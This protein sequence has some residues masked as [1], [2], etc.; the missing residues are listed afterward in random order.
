MYR[1]NPKA[2][3]NTAQGRAH[4]QAPLSIFDNRFH[5]HDV[6][7]TDLTG[8]TRHGFD[9][10]TGRSVLIKFVHP[11]EISPVLLLQ[12][13]HE[14]Q[15]LSEINHPNIAMLL[16][17]G[18]EQGWFWLVYEF[19]ASE[20]LQTRFTR[21]VLSLTHSLQIVEQILQATHALHQH[22][23]VPRSLRPENVYLREDGENI[24]IRLAAIDSIDSSLFLSSFDADSKHFL[25]L[26]ECIPPEQSGVIDDAFT[27]L[28]NIYAVGCLLF[29]SLSGRTPYQATTLNELLLRQAT[30]QVPKLRELGVIVPRAVDEIIQRAMSREQQERYQSTRAMADD[31]RQL[32]DALATGDSDPDVSIG[33]SDYRKSLLQPSFVARTKE[34]DQLNTVIQRTQDGQ[35]GLLFL[36]GQS[37]F[38]KS[39]LTLEFTTRATQHGISVYRGQATSD[40]VTSP[41]ELLEGIA[42]GFEAACRANP[43]L[44]VT[45]SD[46][47]QEQRF[48]VA[49]ALPRLAKLLDAE[50]TDREDS[51]PAGESRTLA[52]LVAFL[53]ALGS[54]DCPAVV[55]LDDCQWAADLVYGLLQRWKMKHSSQQPLQ[56]FVQLVVIFREEE[57]A[58]TDA[59]RKITP[60]A[61]IQLGPLGENDVQRLVESMAGPL[62]KQALETI[63]RLADGVPFMASAILHGLVESQALLPGANGWEVDVNEIVKARS[64]SHAAAFLSQRMSQLRPDTRRLLSIGAV[65][66]SHFDLMAAMELAG[67]S[68]SD[69]IEAVNDARQRH[70][71]WCQ[72]L[73]GTCSFVHDKVRET[74]LSLL[75]D[76]DRKQLHGN[77]ATFLSLKF[78][79]RAAELA[80]HFDAAGESEQ[81]LPYALEAASFAH[82]RHALEVAEQQYAIAYR[83]MNYAS[84]EKRFAITSNLGEVLMLRGKYGPAEKMLQE[85]SRWTLGTQAQA[86]VRGMQGELNK[87]RGDMEGAV[88]DFEAALQLLGRSFPKSKLGVSIAI[89]LG[90]L[91]QFLHTILPSVFV[92]QKKRLPNERERLIMRLHSELSHGYWYCRSVVRCLC[93]HM[94][95]MNFGE[96][97]LPSSELAQAYSDHAPAMLLMGW[98]QRGIWYVERSYQIR[99]RQ[100]D[101]W[102]QGQSLSFHGIIYYAAARYEECI[103]KCRRAVQILERTGDFWQVH[104]ARYQIAA[105]YY[106]LG[107]IE[108]ALEECRR[109][110]SSGMMLGDEQAS[111]II[112]DVWAR[113]AIDR[114]PES[115]L[116]AEVARVR[117][118]AQGQAQVTLARAVQFIK[119]GDH[120]QAG[121]L[122]RVTA[123]NVE[124]A[125][126]AN[127]Y[128]MPVYSWHATAWRM[129]AESQTALN[130][131]QRK[132]CLKRALRSL[133][134]ALGQSWR[135]KNELPHLYRELALVEAMS[136]RSR[137]ARRAIKASIAIAVRQQAR[138]EFAHTQAEMLRIAREFGWSNLD[139]LTGPVPA[140]FSEGQF[141][142]LDVTQHRSGVHSLSLVDRFETLMQSG[143]NISSALS[144]DVICSETES[145]AK[146]LLRCESVKIVW[147]NE[148]G[149]ITHFASEPSSESRVDDDLI[150]KAVQQRTVISRIPVDLDTGLELPI[151]EIVAPILVRNEVVA[152]LVGSHKGRKHIFGA[153]EEKIAKFIVNLAG[154]AFENAEGFAQLEQLNL[155]L[156]HRVAERT[157]ALQQRAEQ[158]TLSND[159]LERVA[160]ELRTTQSQLVVSK[161]IAEEANSAKSRFLAAMSHEIRTPMN[162]IIGMSELALRSDLDRQQQTYLQTVR[163]SAKSL[164]I[165]LNDILDFSKIEAGKMEVD[166]IP[167]N[168]HDSV[169]DAVRL[170]AA[171]A[172]QKSLDLNCRIRP[173]VSQRLI[174]DPNRLRQILVNL[175]G[176]AMKFTSSGSVGVEV[177]QESSDQFQ[178]S[179]HVVVKDTGIGIPKDVQARIFSPF[180][181]GEASVTRRYGG[182]GL[183]L[184]I[185]SQLVELMNGRIWVES[186]PGIGSEFHFVIS[187]SNDQQDS[188]DLLTTHSA[189]HSSSCLVYSERLDVLRT[190][191]EDLPSFGFDVLGANSFE[192]AQAITMLPDFGDQCT[193]LFD[194]DQQPAS[195]VRSIQQ[196]ISH[197]A[198]S[199][200]SFVIL[201]PAGIETSLV[202]LRA[203]GVTSILEKPVTYRVITDT[204]TSR[205]ISEEKSTPPEQLIES[206]HPP[207][208]ILVVD[209]SDINLEV[210][211]GILEWFG[212]DVEIASSGAEA[213][214][215]L[216]DRQFDLVFMDIEMP[217]MDGL[218]TMKHYNSF[219]H[220]AGRKQ[221]TVYAMTA[222]VLDSMKADCLA[223][224]MVGF[225]SKPIEVSELEDVLTQHQ[226]A[227]LQK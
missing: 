46:A 171:T 174:G 120:Q 24:Q 12:I 69:A 70:L 7:S 180:D 100:G 17:S 47:L 96:R 168:L 138:L 112:L 143:R 39:R 178:T 1:D 172:A 72:V 165:I 123:M 32:L 152:C 111:G 119:R 108:S 22:G 63:I 226:T 38:G 219:V 182:T 163:S 98:F 26:A 51:S 16:Q 222:H 5:V 2:Q 146:R 115:I 11:Q 78:P 141:G 10:Q 227:S 30:M 159:Q 53:D 213:L 43:E 50:T 117:P 52:A 173:N 90:V 25:Q 110:Y 77:A 59:L 44:A 57:V 116:D 9:R 204:L 184:S 188:S 150:K 176:N 101:L 86:E 135:F 83:G 82:S 61:H 6:A 121:E 170:F 103:E 224:G 36:E 33:A 212:Q 183:G 99:T 136:G 187:L 75:S 149:D 154:A 161:Q 56:N 118:D 195:A 201:A 162:G 66:G 20:T 49:K 113:C 157:T 64:S 106:R 54:K 155:T 85:A 15:A 198:I 37:G 84:N 193:L 179:I 81:A 218:T 73:D 23:I 191:E 223:A 104:I 18:E 175:L 130:P 105:A 144:R 62:P 4:L 129:T 137:R 21:G 40:A 97:F 217:E 109:N 164:L 209:D 60:D 214:R 28:S 107:D 185:S 35:A 132:Q 34:L 196:L 200:S 166:S 102:G 95:G 42:I 55:I 80:Y 13:Q 148:Q 41:F 19:D 68:K 211:K 215:I 158:L 197:T 88:K 140:S 45:I 151:S 203:M 79:E 186:T 205:S 65:L 31:V 206:D 202:E 221:A 190:Y 153:D 169:I 199:P 89:V 93:A 128:T 58:P 194:L 156:E 122:L 114:L 225:I 48:T 74:I 91:T 76:Q 87:K 207:L 94:R 124:K 192:L 145:A 134:F 147:V 125:G 167:F 71:L 216:E 133:R 67:F 139:Q 142:Q 3:I 8:S 181:Q 131:S 126:V 210:A 92:H 208:K 160:S 127:P 220:T 177:F 27:E 29:W 189:S 14:I